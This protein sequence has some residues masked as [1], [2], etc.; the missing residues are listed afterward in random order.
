MRKVIAE[1]E[2]GDD[3]F[4]EDPVVNALQEKVAAM[5]GFEAGLFVPSGTMS[6]Q[7][8]INLLTAPGGE[9]LIDESGHIINY[10]STALRT[11][12][13]YTCVLFQGGGASFQ[14][15]CSGIESAEQ[16]SGSR[17]RRL[18]LLRIPPIKEAEPVIPMLN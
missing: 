13:R 8:C 15:Q 2:V 11:S 3:V 7:L 12:P 18:W 9:V 16:M 17:R 10:E 5:F 1:A 14:S 4:G 6:N